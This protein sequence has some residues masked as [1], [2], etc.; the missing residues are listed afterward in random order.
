MHTTRPWRR[1]RAR[2][3]LEQS[4][5][6]QRLPSI[7][8]AGQS[9]AFVVALKAQPTG[10]EIGTRPPGRA[11]GRARVNGEHDP[12]NTGCILQIA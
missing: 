2:Q 3:H 1:V 6:T 12:A 9:A 7:R 10:G 11:P 5:I 4:E 8:H